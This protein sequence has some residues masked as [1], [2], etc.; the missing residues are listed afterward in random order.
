MRTS[1]R[2]LNNS[3]AY[4]TLRLMNV[5][6]RIEYFPSGANR[7]GAG[8]ITALFSDLERAKTYKRALIESGKYVESDITIS[9]ADEEGRAVTA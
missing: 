2:D 5:Y 6:F 3:S 1:K 7:V 8:G 9:T 4:D